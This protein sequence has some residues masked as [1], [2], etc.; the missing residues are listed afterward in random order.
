VDLAIGQDAIIR[1]EKQSLGVR[2]DV[3]NLATWMDST[4]FSLPSPERI[5]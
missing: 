4:T 1:R 5:S 3:V 2:I